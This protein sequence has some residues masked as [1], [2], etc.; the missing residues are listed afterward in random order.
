MTKT[1]ELNHDEINGINKYAELQDEY[2]S[3]HKQVDNFYDEIHEMFAHEFDIDTPE[4]NLL[5]N[6][7][8]LFKKHVEL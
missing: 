4:H 3:F 1:I 8:E 5:N 6:I 7:I 2:F